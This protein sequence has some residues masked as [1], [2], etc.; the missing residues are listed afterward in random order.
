M[1]LSDFFTFY[2]FSEALTLAALNFFSV[3]PHQKD[4]EPN[5]SKFGN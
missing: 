1:F 2:G 5:H 4:A 3:P